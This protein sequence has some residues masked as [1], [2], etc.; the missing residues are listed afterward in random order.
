MDV[1]VA[2]VDDL[3]GAGALRWRWVADRGVAPPRDRE[4][5]IEDFVAWAQENAAS[6]QCYVAVVEGTVAGMAWLAR[7]SR[8]PS[9]SAGR[10]LSGDVQSV[11][12]LPEHRGR[13]LGR[14]LVAAVLAAARLEGMERVTV[15]SSEE[16]VRTYRLSGFVGS[17]VLLQIDLAEG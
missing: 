4:Q 6:H 15:H 17:P 3:P 12:V 1:R 10:R 8:V 14:Q 7:L 11:Y 16:A 13:G 5:F 9:P 2:R